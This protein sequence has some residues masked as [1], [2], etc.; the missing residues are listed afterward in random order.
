M[1]KLILKIISQDKKLLETEADSVSVPTAEGEV[2]ILPKHM[3][4]FSKLQTGEL[5]Y[6]RDGQVESVVV[7]NGFMD[8]NP[9][10]EVVI[11]V[12]TAT[13]E[14]DLSA[15]R[16][17]QAIA[18]AKK[19]METSAD[20]REL[21]LAEAELRRAMWELRVAQKSKKARI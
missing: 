19:T 6:K 7:A 21:I 15:A 16:A 1:K 11:M 18:D 5:K 12:D 4:L 17:Q 10:N 14:R 2:T 8:V 3:P 20:Q 9:D 13:L